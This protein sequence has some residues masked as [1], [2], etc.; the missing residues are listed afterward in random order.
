MFKLK[1]EVGEHGWAKIFLRLDDQSIE[2][3]VS[4]LHDSLRD[5]A[6]IAVDIKNGNS[7]M[8]AIFRDEPGE[9]QL[10]VN[11]NGKNARIEAWQYEGGLRG[12]HIEPKVVLAGECPARRIQHQITNSLFE[13]NRDLGP[14][15]Y[16]EQWKNHD[17]PT[18]LYLEL[19]NNRR[20]TS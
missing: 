5:L 3:R 13:I 19:Q 15:K 9:L 6:Q 14:E 1:Y 11:I 12:I 10:I 16:K 8:T 17:F 4:Y 7:E 2:A 20:D 18:N